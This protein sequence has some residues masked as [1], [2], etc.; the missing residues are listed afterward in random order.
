MWLISLVWAVISCT[1]IAKWDISATFPS[2]YTPTGRLVL[3]SFRF[4]DVFFML[5]LYSALGTSCG[6]PLYTSLPS[7]FRMF[8]R[9]NI[10][11]I[12]QLNFYTFVFFHFFSFKGYFS[13]Y[14][15][16]VCCFLLSVLFVL[17]N[18]RSLPLSRTRV[19]ELSKIVHTDGR[20]Q[21]RH[22]RH[23]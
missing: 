16:L 22:C 20:L 10:V 1:L 14:N 11:F 12:F 17:K 6:F 9:G 15:V 8:L 23:I 7:P 5:T 4:P 3:P 21:Q 19:E 18:C 2:M 13:S